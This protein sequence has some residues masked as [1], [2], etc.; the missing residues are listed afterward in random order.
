MEQQQASCF[1]RHGPTLRYRV[2][3]PRP[4]EPAVGSG[5]PSVPS[6][7]GRAEGLDGSEG[8]R[9]GLRGP[10]PALHPDSAEAA[11]GAGGRG[12]AFILEGK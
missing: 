7:R 10:G 5:A 4:P 3:F 2:L 12:M 8:G 11:R 6:R 1:G 9:A